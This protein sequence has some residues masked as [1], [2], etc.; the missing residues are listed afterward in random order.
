VVLD[1]SQLTWQGH[2][3][4]WCHDEEDFVAPKL[5]QQKGGGAWTAV[6]PRPIEVNMV[7]C[8]VVYLLLITAVGARKNRGSLDRIMNQVL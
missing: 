2:T 1:V 4:T 6:A 5:Y 3:L 7:G 8:G